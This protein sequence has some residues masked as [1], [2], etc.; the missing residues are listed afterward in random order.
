MLFRATHGDSFSFLNF[1]QAAPFD[2]GGGTPTPPVSLFRAC[3]G[4]VVCHGGPGGA[5][6][7]GPHAG[8]W[9]QVWGAG[10]VAGR[11]P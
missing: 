5:L 3:G 4:G 9:L 11:G 1:P 6:Q 8:A 7:A 10:V 2:T